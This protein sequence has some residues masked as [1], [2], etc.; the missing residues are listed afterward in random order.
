MV[1]IF[2]TANADGT[3]LKQLLLSVQ[4]KENLNHEDFN[5]RCAIKSSSNAWMNE[6]LI[7]IWIKQAL[8]AFSFSRKF[9]AWDSYK[10]HMTDSIRKDLKRWMWSLQ[11]GAQNIF[12]HLMYVGI[13]YLKWGWQNCIINGIVKVCINLLKVEI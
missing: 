3:T 8:G 10:C 5:S 6:E 11:V 12:K 13:S 4:P 7:T 9:L 2:L 1:G